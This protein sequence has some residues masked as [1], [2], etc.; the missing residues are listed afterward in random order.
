[1]Q[2]R[3]QDEVRCRYA[4]CSCGLGCA[5]APNDNRFVDPLKFL[6]CTLGDD[7]SVTVHDEIDRFMSENQIVVYQP[8]GT[9]RLNVCLEYETAWLMQLK[10]AES[11]GVQELFNLDVIIAVGYLA[12]AQGIMF[13]RVGRNR[14]ALGIT[15]GDNASWMHSKTALPQKL[16]KGQA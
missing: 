12:V 11:L 7:D 1:M 13:R 8:N 9:I 14:F 15:Y 3:R 16:H 2:A 5:A 10:I 4:R 6:S